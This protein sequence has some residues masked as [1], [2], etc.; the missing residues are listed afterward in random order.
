MRKPFSRRSLLAASLTAPIAGLL[1]PRSAKAQSIAPT[2]ACEEAQEVTPRQTAGPFFTPNAPERSSLIEPGMTGRRLDVA[3]LVID[4]NCRP[5]PGALIEVWHADPKG[6]Y[7][8]R[9]YR[10]RGHLFADEQGSYLFETLQP[11]LYPGRTRH[12][13][14][15]VQASNGP[16]LTT[17]L[18]FPNEV[19]NARDGLYRPELLMQMKQDGPDLKGRFDFVLDIA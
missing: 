3:G 9:G 15:R 8:N 5:I 13:H 12:L 18:Y 11:G 19:L 1:A 2:P 4:R 7:D 17:Q 10:F 14:L 16:V 6:R